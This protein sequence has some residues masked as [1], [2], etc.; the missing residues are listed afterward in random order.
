MVLLLMCPCCDCQCTG[1]IRMETTGFDASPPIYCNWLPEQSSTVIYSVTG[2]WP[3][4]ETV[5]CVFQFRI[6]NSSFRIGSAYMSIYDG[7]A[8]LAIVANFLGFWTAFYQV[9]TSAC[10]GLN[11]SDTIVFTDADLVS[12]SGP[13]TACGTLTYTFTQ[14]P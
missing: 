12:S 5:R 4:S 7:V 10:P 9:T 8:R 11:S 6:V 13:Y 2:I 14:C 1:C 3:N